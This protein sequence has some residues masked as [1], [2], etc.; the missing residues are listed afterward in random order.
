MPD[1][2]QLLDLVVLSRVIERGSFA[3]AAADLGVPP[4]TL[5]RRV[6]G[7]ERRLGVRVLERTTR[8]LRPTEIGEMLA[9]RGGRVRKELE[10][11]ERAVADHQRAPRGLLRLSV[12]TPV[13]DDFLG[14][15]LAEYLRR[16]PDMRIEVV[17]E[18]RLVDLVTEGFDAAIRIAK[19]ADSSLGTVR[20]AVVAPV[21]AAAPRYL[22][23]APP[24]RHPRDLA[25]PGHAIIAFGKR[26]R[27]TWSFVGRGAATAEVELAPRAVAGSAPLVA[28]LA[29]DGAGIANVPR[30]VAARF[31]L[32][33]IEPGGFRPLAFDLS[34]VTPSA[35]M[36][37]PKV[38]AFVDLMRDFVAD[39]PDMFDA[40]V[41][42]RKA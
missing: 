30:F 41:P 24:L 42:R 6:A 15:A 31:G 37:A 14:P 23:R 9:E 34:I 25:D 39:R 16:Y 13:A 38:R 29:A 19:L 12:P 18:D 21:L 32:V 5:S 27:Q 33:V 36:A 20:L 26:R 1:D 22:D 11:A 3:R 10:D 8:S 28:Q 40:V 35:R 2:G 17:A 7:L 4:S